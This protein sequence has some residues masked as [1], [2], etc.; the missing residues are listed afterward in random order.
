MSADLGMEAV[1]V[2]KISDTAV[3]NACSRGCSRLRL[4]LPPQP[5]NGLGIRN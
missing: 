4:C 2:L 1:E 5:K 3:V